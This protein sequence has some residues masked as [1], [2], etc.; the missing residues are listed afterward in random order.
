MSNTHTFKLGQSANIGE[1]IGC[2]RDDW[3]I[4]HPEA[5]VAVRHWSISAQDT[6]SDSDG[7][8]IVDSKVEAIAYTI[9]F[10]GS[11]ALQ[12][13]GK[14][15]RPIFNIE[16]G[17]EFQV[18]LTHVESIQAQESAMDAREKMFR[19]IELDVNRRFKAL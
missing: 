6:G 10:W 4:D 19:Q 5:L 18:D 12:L 8:Y 14:R 15:S 3:G 16:G 7:V 1:D 11:D 13:A 2:I 17:E 9:S